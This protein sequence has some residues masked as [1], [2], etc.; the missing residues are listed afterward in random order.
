[1]RKQIALL[2][3]LFLIL[4]AGCSGQ[5]N[6]DLPAQDYPLTQDVVEAA[7]E[8]CGLPG[9][10]T[11]ETNDLLKYEGIESTSYT[12]RHPTKDVFAGACMG[13]LT[14]KSEAF[15]SLGINL[16]TIDQSEE[17]TDE[18]IRQTIRY[19]VY[20]FWGE[21]DP[22]IEEAFFKQYV[23]GEPLQ[24]E[25]KFDGID[26]QLVYNPDARQGQFQIAFST[27]MEAQLNNQ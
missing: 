16:S 25:K 4:L 12:L 15:T 9:D 14:H 10:L 27:D 1:M 18:E 21:E 26:C 20:L 3:V 19:A 13:I 17:T 22:G 23:Q 24:W 6:P 11:V 8:Q 5:S 7:M 2:L